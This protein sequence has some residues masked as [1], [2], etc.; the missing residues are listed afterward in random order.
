MPRGL[1]RE[2]ALLEHE[3]SL[4]VHPLRAAET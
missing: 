3:D 4:D 1:G 2:P